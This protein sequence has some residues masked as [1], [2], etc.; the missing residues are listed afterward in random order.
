MIY[1][2]LKARAELARLI[3]SEK[4]SSTERLE[5]DTAAHNAERVY[6]DYFRQYE[7]LQRAEP[8]IK[9]DEKS[10]WELKTLFRKSCSL[11]HPD[12]VNKDK[13]EVAHEIFVELRE[14]YRCN[15]VPRV[16]G[17]YEKLKSGNFNEIGSSALRKTEELR[18]TIKDLELK[19][20]QVLGE[21]RALQE[22]DG[23]RLMSTAGAT[24]VEWMIYFERQQLALEKEAARIVSQ[25]QAAQTEE[26][27]QQ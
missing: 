13:K 9:L 23:A 10:E 15:D 6:E 21:L 27:R 7:E 11:C 3:A 2:I 22:S 4:A 24:E 16:R 1:R 26:I 5:A 18:V 19:L 25:I 14:A 12:K 20:N 8:L 17:I